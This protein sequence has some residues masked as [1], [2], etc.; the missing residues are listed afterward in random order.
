MKYG[1]K[2]FGVF[3]TALAFVAGPSY[4]Q[5]ST[6]ASG[7]WMGGK[8]DMGLY[9]GGS[10]GASKTDID[11]S[12]VPLPAGFTF[13]SFS[14][15]D[16]DTGFKIFGGYRMHRNMAV[17]FGYTRLGKFSF[18]STTTPAAT[19]SHTVKNDGWNIDL[20]GILPLPHN[21]SLF[22]RVGAYFN[23]SKS[24]TSTTGALVAR[25]PSAKESKTSLKYGVGA[26]YDFT[27]N[28]AVRGEWERYDSLGDAATTG[29]F[30]VNLY[31]VGVVWR[32]Q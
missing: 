24:N 25:T 6:G 28:L 4:G 5:T 17:E 21:F 27:R 16:S 15:D 11:D 13:T 32:F 23:E 1:N 14:S 7:A 30:D 22:A 12:G 18:S 29:E 8:M 20:V 9:L 2:L 10:A 19:A 3:V 31:T 26:Q